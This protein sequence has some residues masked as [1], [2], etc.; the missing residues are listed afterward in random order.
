M[1]YPVIMK[2]SDTATRSID[3]AGS[4]PNFG[5]LLRSEKYADLTIKSGDRVWLAHKAIICSQCEFFDRACTGGFS[6]SNDDTI[7]LDEDS[8]VAGALLQ[9]LYAGDYKAIAADSEANY[10]AVGQSHEHGEDPAEGPCNS[11]LLDVQMCICAD[12]YNLPTLSALAIGKFK[13]HLQDTWATWS[14]VGAVCLLYTS[15]LAGEA[16]DE[17]EIGPEHD[18]TALEAS[19]PSGALHSTVS[20]FDASNK[21]VQLLLMR[22]PLRGYLL[23]FLSE[24]LSALAHSPLEPVIAIRALFHTLPLFAGDICYLTFS[25]SWRKLRRGSMHSTGSPQSTKSGLH[26]PLQPSSGRHN[27]LNASHTP[28]DDDAWQVLDNQTPIR[29]RLSLATSAIVAAFTKVQHLKLP[30]E[31][32]LMRDIGAES[33]LVITQYMILVWTMS[34]FA[35]GCHVEGVLNVGGNGA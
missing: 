20:G 4:V 9:F 19:S 15:P 12:K 32:V 31:D 26:I 25:Q 1:D 33:A 10:N 16:I 30:E 18:H 6:E 29:R 17:R 13:I 5:S 28:A 34:L 22:S 3:R 24:H 35:R 14:L 8:G 2:E 23:E 21:V 7:I 11:L 27:T